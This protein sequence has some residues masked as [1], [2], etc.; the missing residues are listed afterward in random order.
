MTNITI[1]LCTEDR[2]RIDRLT[3]ALEAMAQNQPRQLYAL[4]L[5]IAPE[6]DAQ[7][8]EAATPEQTQPKT[9]KPAEA[10]KEAPAVTVE[11]LR[12]KYMSLAAS[13]KKQDA[14]ALIKQY[15]VKISEI[16]ADKRAE[17]LEKL[18]ALEG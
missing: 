8:P 5:G 15:A 14:V 7:E 1:E 9:E 6:N 4:D 18:S 12:S 13:P 2:A 11:D 3:E 16:P 10:E 17:V